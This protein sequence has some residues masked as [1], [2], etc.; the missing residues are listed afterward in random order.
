MEMSPQE[1]HYLVEA[2]NTVLDD[3]GPSHVLQDCLQDR[4]V[5]ADHPLPRLCTGRGRVPWINL[6]NLACRGQLVQVVIEVDDP[7]GR[8]VP[9][10]LHWSHSRQAGRGAASRVGTG[11]HAL[12]IVLVWDQ[13]FIKHLTGIGLRV[14]GLTGSEVRLL[15]LAMRIGER[16]RIHMA[17][18]RKKVVDNM[19]FVGL[20][21]KRTKKTISCC[22][23]VQGT[24]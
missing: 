9:G 15:W 8:R 2:V 1:R 5:M 24:V 18:E 14:W 20:K 7:R 22:P 4:L 13:L 17:G 23:N 6:S 3:F 10:V 19:V 11:T 12:G 21:P 16:E